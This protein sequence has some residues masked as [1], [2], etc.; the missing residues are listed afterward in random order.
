MSG[1]LGGLVVLDLTR[2]VWGG[3]SAALLGDFG[4]RVIRVE[5]LNGP[6]PDW[7]RDGEHPPSGHQPLAKLVHRNKQSVG[8]ALAHEAGREALDAMVAESDVLLTDWG[9]DELASFGLT[10]ERVQTLR[11]EIIYARGS[12]MGPCGPDAL[13]PGLDEI[14]AARTGTMSSL[15]EPGQPPVYTATGPMYTAV[16]LAMGIMT[17]LY[18]R[19]ETGEGQS[20]DASLYAGNLY[21]ATLTIDAYLAMRDDILGEPRARF[22]AANPMSG[23][24]YPASDGRWVTVTMPDTDRWWPAFAEVMG[25]DVDDPRF[26]DH[27]KRCGENR[28]EMMQ[29]LE[30]L[31]GAKP[32]SHWK[33]QFD[34]YRLSADIIERYDYPA[35]HLQ[36]AVN[37]YVIEAPNPHQGESLQGLGFPIHLA[38]TPAEVRIPAPRPGENSV[39]VLSDLLGWS[40]E[41]IGQLAADSMI[42]ELF[43]EPPVG[44][45]GVGPA[46]SPAPEVHRV[47]GG[48]RP[49]EGLL[50]LDATVWFQGPV[51]GQ[52]LADFGAEVIHIERPVTGDQARGVRSIA[53]VPVADW[54]QYFLCVN[55]NKKSLAVDLKSEAGR[56]LMHRLVEK[57]DVFLWN[58]GLESLPGLGLDAETLLKINPRLIH[59][60]NS[61]YGNQGDFNKPSFDMTVQA[62]TG[63][64]ARQG[65]PG[66]PP[67]YLGLGAG[68]AYGGLMS[69]LGILL[70]LQ[71]RRH[72]GR[73]QSLDASLYGAQ[74]FLGAPSLQPYLAERDEW[75]ADQHSRSAPRNPLWNRYPTSEG[76]LFLCVP[77]ED[78]AWARL[79]QTLGQ[80]DWARDPRWASATARAADSEGLVGH[81]DALFATASAVDWAE[82]LADSGLTASPIVHIRDL[83][84]DRQAWANDYL[85]KAHCDEIGEEVALRG[86]PVTLSR[87]PGRVDMLGP[88]LGQDTEL[89]LFELLGIDWDRIGE[90]KEQGIIP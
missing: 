49:L 19:E 88:E 24:F 74:L 37:R 25:L 62:L 54:N 72:T 48:R 79:C 64:M 8:L 11:P 22:D 86:L 40:E 57:A 58:Q 73:G 63:I 38:E 42:G 71:A 28:L 15:P 67:I 75:Y 65:E 85:V 90:L 43:D 6:R 33:E 60:T 80:G 50:V 66:Q 5:N 27:E 34:E 13:A 18:H 30:E 70:A 17:A 16:M 23:I 81:L 20:V 21:A 84:D 46:S 2:E 47:E 3:L 69:A 7:D 68:D 26:D 29:V 44:F 12:G 39:D 61:G 78:E 36:A 82:R 1:A 83:P 77:N 35:S 10:A 51:C 4:A 76:W 89:T 55:R 9:L 31:F 53:A 45:V 32:S 52:Y 14:A 56:D 87:T 59:A 41:R